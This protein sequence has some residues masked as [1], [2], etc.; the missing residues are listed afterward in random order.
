MDMEG[1]RKHCMAKV[2]VNVEA[3]GRYLCFV[4]EKRGLWR[5]WL[6]TKM[7]VFEPGCGPR[8]RMPAMA[9]SEAMR[10]GSCANLKP[11]SMIVPSK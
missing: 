3:W 10:V 2:E 11:C 9:A 7:A 5:V 8:E 1:W 4:G 6:G